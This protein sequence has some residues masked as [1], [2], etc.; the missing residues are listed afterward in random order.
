MRQSEITP[1]IVEISKKIAEK[2]RM[3]IYEGCWIYDDAND[4]LFMTVGQ[5]MIDKKIEYDGKFQKPNHITF[6][7]PSSIMR[8]CIPIPSLSDA[9]DAIYDRS[10]PFGTFITLEKRFNDWT[11]GIITTQE[12]HEAVLEALLEVLKEDK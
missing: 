5:Y 4:E 12:L 2:W 11:H 3:E 7:D 8:K 9:L 1:K 10:C 6:S